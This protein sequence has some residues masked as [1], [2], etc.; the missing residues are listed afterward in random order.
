MTSIKSSIEKL[1]KNQR[2]QIRKIAAAKA[3][4]N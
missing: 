2:A 1:P 4:V 3:G